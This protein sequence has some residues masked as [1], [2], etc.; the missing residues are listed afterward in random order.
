MTGPLSFHNL[1][2]ENPTV[3]RPLPQNLT[4]ALILVKKEVKEAW[5]RSLLAQQQVNFAL[6]LHL[7]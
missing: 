7:I 2:P 3:D 5:L 6:H 4:P 1:S